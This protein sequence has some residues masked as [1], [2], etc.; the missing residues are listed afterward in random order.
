METTP[1]LN[2]LEELIYVLR[3][4]SAS[5]FILWMQAFFVGGGVIFFYYF[6]GK[7]GELSILDII[8]LSTTDAEFSQL[9]VS[10]TVIT[11]N[12]ARFIKFGIK[13]SIK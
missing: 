6:T 11:H 12:Y 8:S 7:W 13:L 1:V 9:S 10:I 4:V 2:L 3:E 5:S